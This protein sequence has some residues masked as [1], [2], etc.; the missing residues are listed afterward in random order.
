MT[1]QSA[2]QQLKNAMTEIPVSAL[3]NFANQFVVEI[4]AF[5]YGLGVVLM[6]DHRPTDF[7]SKKIQLFSSKE[8]YLSES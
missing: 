7:F 4:D 3:P 1:T 6:Q 8:V 2:F 5:G